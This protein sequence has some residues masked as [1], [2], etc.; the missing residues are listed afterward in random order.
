MKDKIRKNAEEVN[1]I[2]SEVRRMVLDTTPSYMILIGRHGNEIP[3]QKLKEN[4]ECGVYYV[5]QKRGSVGETHTHAESKEHFIL[6]TGSVKINGKLLE[7][8]EGLCIPAGVPHSCE[9]VTDCEYIAVTVPVE[10]EYLG[11]RRG[12]K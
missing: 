2:A 9:A 12:R 7:I 10:R 1:R 8:G 4:A 5:F 3:V 11:N 6:V